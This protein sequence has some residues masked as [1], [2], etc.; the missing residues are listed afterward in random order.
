MFSPACR[1]PLRR[2]LT[3]CPRLRY[4]LA[5]T[6][7][8]SLTTQTLY[9]WHGVAIWAAGVRLMLWPARRIVNIGKP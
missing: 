8:P 6:G 1:L 2:R 4:R 3:E 9:S 5:A 7:L